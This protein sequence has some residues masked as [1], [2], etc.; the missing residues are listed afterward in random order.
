MLQM[1]NHEQKLQL[2]I[3]LKLILL[4]YRIRVYL[5]SLLL[6]IL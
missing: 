3:L 6:I 1:Y 2:G 5:L 4:F